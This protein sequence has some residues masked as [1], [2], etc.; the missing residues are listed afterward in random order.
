MRWS[1]A[2][3]PT[4]KEDPA[5]AEVVSHKLML[6]A[7]MISKVGSGIYTLM[8][9]GLIVTRKIEQ[10]VR[11]EMNRIGAHESLM[12]ILSPAELWKET[13]RWEIYGDE[14][15][16]MKDRHKRDFVLGP[17]HEEIVT[18]LVRGRLRSYKQLPLTLY[19]I[20]TKFRDERRPRFGLMRGREFIMK[21]AYS[22]NRDEECLDRSY[23]DMY[24]AYDAIFRRCGLRFR[25]VLGDSG[26]IGGDFTHEFMVL[27]NTGESAVISCPSDECAYA[28]T[29]E[30]AES[31]IENTSPDGEAKPLEEVHTPE[32]KTVDAVCSFLETEPHGIVKT[33]LYKNGEEVVAALIRG[34]RE[35]CEP[36][37]LRALQTEL[38]EMADA[39]TV[40][41]AS[42]AEVGFAGP[43]G[44][45]G[46]KLVADK[47]VM[48]MRNFVTGANKTDYHLTNVNPKRDFEPDI[49]SD[50]TLA[51]AGDKC[52][53][54]GRELTEY[55]GIEVGQVFKLGNKY[56]KA[57]GAVFTEEDGSEVPF[58]MGCYGIGVTRTVAAAIEQNHDENGIIWPRA[59]APYHVLITPISIKDEELMSVAEKTY[60]ELCDRGI[61][62]L[63]DDRDER[64]GV[65]FKDGDLIGIPLR[66]TIGS[67]GLKQ[68]ILEVRTRRTGETQEVPLE[69]AVDKIIE[70][71]EEVD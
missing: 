37:L 10:I 46:V 19:Q 24:G 29:D 69:G 48:E 53:K 28:A 57:M 38:L 26:A 14:L 31:V 13:G 27:A 42:G 4:T 50:I 30:T 15:M 17:T 11:E 25:P 9:L 2:Y 1:K 43:V 18:D 41:S 12:P 71:L 22:F 3:I 34:D 51:V 52:I 59:L 56:S 55:R 45:K 47:T 44:L 66:V 16:R 7:G 8:P 60:S 6:R 62:T 5:E 40:R 21:D 23:R 70:L 32:M 61:E 20:Q 58:L 35:I 33:I 63:L 68:G 64:P 49:V 65:K 36:K 67:R 54:C 39:G